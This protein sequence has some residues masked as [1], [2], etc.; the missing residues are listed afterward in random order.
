MM[1]R[2]VQ[3]M[4][5]LVDDLLDV[6]RISR[7]KIEL[8]KERVELA[9]VVRTP[10]RPAARS[11]RRRRTN[12][13]VNLPPHAALCRRRLDPAGPGVREPAEQR[14]QVHRSGGGRI[15]LARRAARAA[16]PSSAVRD[17]GIGIPAD[18]LPRIF[19]MFTQV[20]RTL[21][22]SQGGLGI[23]LTLVKRLVEM[24]GGSVEA[25]SDGPGK[26]SEFMVRLPL[27][28]PLASWPRP[29]QRRDT[30]QT[31]ALPKP[32]A[33]SWSWTT[34]RTRLTAW[35]A[36]CGIMGNEVTHGPRRPRSAWKRRRR[37]SPT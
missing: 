20:D 18:M 22:R 33:A 9:A 34:T 7:G 28:G 10:S 3:Q 19:E 23:G 24:H 13:T 14:R 1:E 17:N 36:S 16:M 11:S 27:A 32:A 31:A 6:S 12:S 2:Q 4:V 26:G 15:W 30:E 29:P 21:E 8:R 37:S 25:R 5:R 35:H